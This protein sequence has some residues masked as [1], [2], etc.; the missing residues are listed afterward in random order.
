VDH[1]RGVRRDWPRAGP[2]KVVW[3]PITRMALDEPPGVTQGAWL[4]GF[5]TAVTCYVRVLVASRE[6]VGIIY[7][8]QR[9]LGTSPMAPPP[10]PR[11]PRARAHPKRRIINFCNKF[12]PA[13]VW[14]HPF[15]VLS[16]CDFR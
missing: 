3:R 14:R 11:A 2:S 12:D 5:G 16:L 6:I 10:P 13:P 7:T 9:A 8:A 1:A 4:N 15:V